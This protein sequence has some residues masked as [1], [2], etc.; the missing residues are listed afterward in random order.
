[1]N[2]TMVMVRGLMVPATLTVGALLVQFGLTRLTAALGA[3][4]P[5]PL[6]EWIQW[7]W[8]VAVTLIL[9]QFGWRLYAWQSERTVPCQ[10]CG[11]PLGRLRDGRVWY[12]RQLSDFRRCLACDKPN[13]EY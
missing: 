13:S 10:F 4:G 2:W 7:G 6:G 9:G 11:G 1:M 5:H 8:L 12:G 3:D